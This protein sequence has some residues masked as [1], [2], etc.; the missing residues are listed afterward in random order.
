[1]QGPDCQTQKTCLHVEIANPT[2]KLIF[3]N[4]MEVGNKICNWSY[5]HNMIAT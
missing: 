1:M 4:Q 5:I 3:L 2:M